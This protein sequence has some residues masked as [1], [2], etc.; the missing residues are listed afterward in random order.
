MD[1]LG[2]F[3]VNFGLFSSLEVISPD[4]QLF[5][6]E[7]FVGQTVLFLNKF[8]FLFL[9]II[10]HFLLGRSADFFESHVIRSRSSI[11]ISQSSSSRDSDINS[12]RSSF[13]SQIFFFGENF[14]IA[15]VGAVHSLGIV[16]DTNVEIAASFT[17]SVSVETV[18]KTFSS[19]GS[20]F[21]FSRGN[22]I[23]SFLG[24]VFEVS[25]EMV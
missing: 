24:E 17:E 6:V 16:D 8:S 21:S 15:F 2:K 7:F 19:L 22:S 5:H 18:G 10:N 1:L 9:L 14:R 20:E 25:S 3:F 11:I 4:L 12:I 23:A 13:D